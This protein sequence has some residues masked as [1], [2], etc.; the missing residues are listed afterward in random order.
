MEQERLEREREA[1][2]KRE[3][4]LKAGKRGVLWNAV[5]DKE[6]MV[7]TST[8]RKDAIHIKVWTTRELE[9]K[10]NKKDRVWRFG[11]QMKLRKSDRRTTA[12]DEFDLTDGK[13]MSKAKKRL[14]FFATWKLL[15]EAEREFAA[16]LFIQARARAPRAPPRAAVERVLERALA[17]PFFE[18]WWRR[19][20]YRDEPEALQQYQMADV[21]SLAD[22]LQQAARAKPTEIGGKR[23]YALPTL[24]DADI[25]EAKPTLPPIEGKAAEAPVAPMHRRS[26]KPQLDPIG[27]SLDSVISETIGRLCT[28][29]Q[30]FSDTRSGYAYPLDYKVG[31]SLEPAGA[32]RV[33][34]ALDEDESNA[35]AAAAAAA[36]AAQR[37]KMKKDWVLG[38]HTMTVQPAPFERVKEVMEKAGWVREPEEWQQCAQELFQ[39]GTINISARKDQTIFEVWF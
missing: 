9:A 15:D 25:P 10:R 37:E 2:A 20:L 27:G 11:R 13:V 7:T 21:A 36:E 17:P 1:E 28:S 34:D 16:T 4:P 18:V 3:K 29:G 32:M 38:M 26:S 12:F 39:G 8:G 5:E 30:V 14:F 33:V 35:A 23:T 6:Y 22:A 24:D 19:W 31:P